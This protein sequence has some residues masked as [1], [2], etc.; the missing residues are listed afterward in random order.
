MCHRSKWRLRRRGGRRGGCD[1]CASGTVH[2]TRSSDMCCRRSSAHTRMC[3]AAI[4]S[5]KKNAVTLSAVEPST[6]GR[7]FYSCNTAERAMAKV[8]L[9]DGSRCQMWWREQSTLVKQSFKSK[10]DHSYK[11]SLLSHAFKVD[12]WGP[13]VPRFSGVSSSH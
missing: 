9:E 8:N 13:C 10:R 4:F 11:R 3:V 1:M 12:L 2:R 6:H 5:H 7:C